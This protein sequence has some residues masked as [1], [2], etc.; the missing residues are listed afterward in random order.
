[1][2]GSGV[3]KPT[4]N[5]TKLTAPNS[6]PAQVHAEKGIDNSTAL[7]LVQPMTKEQ[8][9]KI[10]VRGLVDGLFTVAELSAPKA[11]QKKGW[12]KGGAR[13]HVEFEKPG[14]KNSLLSPELQ[15]RI[16]HAS[17]QRLVAD[18]SFRTPHSAFLKRKDIT[19][20]P[21]LYLDRADYAMPFCMPCAVCNLR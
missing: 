15:M 14:R 9:E 20:K 10:V 12:R 19:L 3:A 21:T 11:D 8:L 18:V 16:S 5:P 6:K 2:R 4:F 7:A 1:M 17:E 13:T